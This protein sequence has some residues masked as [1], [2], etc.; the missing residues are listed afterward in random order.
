MVISARR[1]V[2]RSIPW[3]GALLAAVGCARIIGIEE[4]P[5]GAASPSEDASID[6]PAD[7][8]AEGAAGD[9]AADAGG[10]SIQPAEASCPRHLPQR[11]PSDPSDGGSFDLV[12]ALRELDFGGANDGWKEL[13][14]DLDGVDTQP[15]AGGASCAYTGGEHSTVPGPWYD[16]ACAMDNAAGGLLSL[17]SWMLPRLGESLTE[18]REAYQEGS[19]GI[20]FVVR[21]Y[22]GMPNDDAV[23]VSVIESTGVP[24][25]LW[26][27]NDPWTLVLESLS[28][29]SPLLSRYVDSTGYVANGVLAARF[30]EFPVRLGVKDAGA[31]LL[32]M[33]DTVISA[34]L[35]MDTTSGFY[36]L[37]DGRLGGSMPT[38][39][40]FGVASSVGTD[41]LTA[42]QINVLVTNAC[43]YRDVIAVEAGTEAGPAC[44]AFSVGARFE[45][46]Q[47]SIGT[48]ES[49]PDIPGVCTSFSCP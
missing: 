8:S 11:N 39:S 29:Q 33:R 17:A 3:I 44:N 28:S 24:S 6:S 23:T 16:N 12:F 2:L 4:R 32:S 35:R 40:L 30:T 34:T 25:P 46:W 49:R 21:G 20:L 36:K 45:A 18:L 22:N 19:R 27:G 48:V 26:Q 10:D 15:D 43:P 37:L 31:A 1:R 41:C 9:A 47:A 7:V 38:E 5:V 13:G 14:F 42:S